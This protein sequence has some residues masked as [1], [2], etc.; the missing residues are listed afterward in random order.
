MIALKSLLE[1]LQ[2]PWDKTHTLPLG[3]R[4]SG[5]YTVEK[6]SSVVL[7]CLKTCCLFTENVLE[8]REESFQVANSQV[9]GI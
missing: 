7:S 1:S 3:N 2:R 4:L 5:Y 6:T 9:N 8:F